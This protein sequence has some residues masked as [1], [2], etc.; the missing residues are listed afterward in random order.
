MDERREE[1]RFDDRLDTL[2]RVS[3]DIRNGPA[4]FHLDSVVRRRQK[5]TQGRECA[6]RYHDLGLEIVTSHQV[7]N[8]LQCR[9]LNGGGWVREELNQPSTKTRFN[10]SLDFFIGAIGETK[11]C[12]TS[13]DQNFVVARIDSLD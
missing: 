7:G 13:V 12:P 11:Y 10:Y 6:C 9:H 1:I 4:R 3:G 5:G 8:G 2:T